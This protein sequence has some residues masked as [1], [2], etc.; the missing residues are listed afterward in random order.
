M[1]RLNDKQLTRV[2]CYL[3]LKEQFKVRRVCRKWKGLVPFMHE[4]TLVLSE[5]RMVANK[6]MGAHETSQKFP[7]AVAN[8][9]DVF[10]GTIVLECSEMDATALFAVPWDHHER[11]IAVI[12]IRSGSKEDLS[13]FRR[14]RYLSCVNTPAVFPPSLVALSLCADDYEGVKGLLD[15]LVRSGSSKTL[16][17]LKWTGSVTQFPSEVKGNALRSIFIDG[18]NLDYEKLVPLL[19]YPTLETV[20]STNK[21]DANSEVFHRLGEEAAARKSKGKLRFVLYDDKFQQAWMDIIKQILGLPAKTAAE[22]R[23]LKQV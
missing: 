8:I 4:E 18:Y 11:I 6:L 16:E 15:K 2:L 1:Q 22:F 17:H 3:P 14:L 21:W 19:G 12:N 13:S 23:S 10:H 9:M 20:A 7:R 5:R